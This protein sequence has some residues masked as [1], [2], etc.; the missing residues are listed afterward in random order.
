LPNV[1]HF[2]K[3]AHKD[4]RVEFIDEIEQVSFEMYAALGKISDRTKV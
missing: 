2:C 1:L 4:K 3:E